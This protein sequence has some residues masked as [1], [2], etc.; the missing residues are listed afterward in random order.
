M[1]KPLA[2]SEL[3]AKAETLAKPQLDQLKQATDGFE[4]IFFKN[5]LTEMQKGT[6]LFGSGPGAGIYQ[7]LMDQTLAD[8]MG[9][10]GSLGI[11]KM[12]FNQIKPVLLSEAEARIRLGKKS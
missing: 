3:S 11:S 7:D 5:L 4:A 9:K 8:S 1:T 10:S 12:L 2:S 6:T